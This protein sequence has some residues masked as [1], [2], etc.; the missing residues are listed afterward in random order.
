MIDVARRANV[1]T[2]TVSRVLRSPEEVK[3]ATRLRVLRSIEEL[4]YQPNVLA[5]QLRENKTNS[6]LVVVPNIMNTVFRISLVE[7]SEWRVR[8]IIV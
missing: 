4:N 1:S 6:I 7:L 2:A 8:I 3:E 5:R